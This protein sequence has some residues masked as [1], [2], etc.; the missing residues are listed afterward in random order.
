MSE[1]HP[2]LRRQPLNSVSTKIISLVFLSTLLTAMVVSWISIQSTYSYL[3]AEIDRGF[4]RLLGHSEIKLRS[5]IE[6]GASELKV[7]CCPDRRRAAKAALERIL[8]KS[9]H[10][11]SL[12][13]LDRQGD[14][15]ASAGPIGAALAA[16]IPLHSEGGTTFGVFS[17]DPNSAAPWIRVS[18]DGRSDK[19]GPALLGVL[20]ADAIGAQ[21]FFGASKSHRALFLTDSTGR[22]LAAV[23]E[24]ADSLLS[25]VQLA[26]LMA[27]P[28]GEVV[29][30]IDPAGESLL[31]SALPLIVPDWTLLVLEPFQTAFEPVLSVVNRIFLSDLCV[32]LLFSLLAYRITTRIMQPIEDLSEGALRISQGQV[33]HEIP[34][35]QSGDELGLLTRTFNE[36]MRKLRR[37]QL[38]IEEANDRLK[39]QY[40]ELLCANEI[41]A[42]LSITDGLTK[43]HNHRYFQDHLTR[44]I[45]RVGRSGEPLSMLLFDLDDFKGLNDRMGHAAGDE[46][47]VRVANIMVVSV[48]ESDLLARY[49]GEEF[50]VLAPNTGLEGAEALAE[51]I[52][53]AVAEAPHILDES[54]RPVRVTISAGVALFKGDRRKFFQAADRALY[55]AKAEG[56]NCVIVAS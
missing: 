47:L 45:K 16:A 46:L 7:A 36:M 27:N 56:K 42:Q 24:Q 17:P 34:D 31:G 55:Q 21:L 32:I 19:P 51:K 35:S 52:R 39:D 1:P 23:G 18:R 44:E 54:L 43:L 28:G 53:M 4:P 10:F 15:L 30:V 26:E 29:E 40:D 5:W 38:E 11:Q 13:S 41:L 25:R 33:D 49:G 14:V 6:E 22:V 8:E 12:V 9:A 2:P 48:R 50:V 37:N 3:R 20:S